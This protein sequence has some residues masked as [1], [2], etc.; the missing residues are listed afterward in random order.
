MSSLINVYI[1]PYLGSEKNHR[2]ELSW[3]EQ[4]ASNTKVVDSIPLQAIL[5]DPCRCPPIQNIL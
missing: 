4:G 5:D 2:D 3:S 1:H